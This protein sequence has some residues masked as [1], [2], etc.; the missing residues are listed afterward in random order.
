MGSSGIKADS[1][2]WRYRPKYMGDTHTG[3]CT[4]HLIAA[5]NYKMGAGD[6]DKEYTRLNVTHNAPKDWDRLPL[7]P[8][9]RYF[10]YDPKA[11]SFKIDEHL[12]SDRIPHGQRVHL[13]DEHN[14]YC[15][16]CK[17]GDRFWIDKFDAKTEGNPQPKREFVTT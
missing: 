2:Y 5:H 4:E 16:G 1:Y 6:F 15:W 14:W 13:S 9:P 7:P 3:C 12:N 10:L 11:L 8:R 17:K